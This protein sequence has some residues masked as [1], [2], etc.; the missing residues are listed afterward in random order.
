MT[1][2]ILK[3]VTVELLVTRRQVRRWRQHLLVYS[4]AVLDNEDNVHTPR[5]M[6][7]KVTMHEPNPYKHNYKQDWLQYHSSYPWK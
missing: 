5:E 3:L 6:S 7:I 4:S 1:F 2:I